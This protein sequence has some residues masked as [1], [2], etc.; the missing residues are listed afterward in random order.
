MVF[1]AFI[2]GRS[3]LYGGPFIERYNR[4]I[5][6]A[7]LDDFLKLLEQYKFGATQ[8]I[9]IRR[10]TRLLTGCPTGS[11]FTKAMTSP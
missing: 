5:S 6:L 1:P 10:R 7:D 9:R 8:L 4:D 11:A 3:E 2:D